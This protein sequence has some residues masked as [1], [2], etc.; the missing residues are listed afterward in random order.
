MGKQSDY[1]C[2]KFYYQHELFNRSMRFDYLQITSSLWRFIW[3]SINQKSCSRIFNFYATKLS[4]CQPLNYWYHD[5]Y[6]VDDEYMDLK[7]FAFLQFWFPNYSGSLYLAHC[8]AV[9]GNSRS[10]QTL[11]HTL[12]QQIENKLKSERIF[13]KIIRQITE[14]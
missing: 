2:L 9:R 7:M 3:T 13:S 14:G 11:S 1:Y 8:K 4:F 5:F 6:T 10:V 12:L